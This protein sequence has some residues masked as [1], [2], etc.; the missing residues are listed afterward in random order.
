MT[1]RRLG[2]LS[3]GSARRATTWSMPGFKY[4]MMDLQAAIGLH[5]LAAHRPSLRAARGDLRRATTRRSR[6]CRSAR[7]RRC[8]RATSTPDIST[9]CWSIRRTA[10]IATTSRSRSPKQ[11]L[12]R[13]C[14]SRGAS[15]QLLRDRFGFRRGQFPHAE[16]DRGHRAVAAALA[17]LTDEQVDVVIARCAACLEPTMRQRPAFAC[18]FARRLARAPAS[19]IS[20]AAGRSLAR[21]AWAARSRSARRH[22]PP[23]S[24]AGWVGGDA[25]G[26]GRAVAR[27][28]VPDL[29]VIDDPSASDAARWVRR[30]RGSA[31]RSPSIHDLGLAR[32]P[33]DLSDRRQLSAACVRGARAGRSAG[34]GVRD[35]RPGDS[36]SARAPCAARPLAVLIALGGGA[37]VRASASPAPG[38]RRRGAAAA[39]DIAGGLRPARRR[40]A[41][42]PRCR[43]IVAPRRPGRELLARAAVAVVAGGVT[44]YEACALGTPIVRSPVVPAQRPATRGVRRAGAAIDA[45]RRSSRARPMRPRGA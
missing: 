28:G 41:L 14:I 33:S 8:R 20:C 32:V 39:I 31:F 42:P 4:N 12:R 37:H 25:R 1:P 36:R 9:P 15:A 24:L 43:W 3:T 17:G 11:G 18:C 10:A 29:I 13:A 23:P 44:L 35:S 22:R 21:W 26:A 27:G 6:I 34:A 7:S 2:A 38:H 40:R 19:A 16:R 5:Q 30:A 45:S